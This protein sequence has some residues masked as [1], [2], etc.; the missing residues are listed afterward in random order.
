MVLLAGSA[1]AADILIVAQAP[2][3]SPAVQDAIQKAVSVLDDGRLRIAC[4]LGS[5]GGAVV[6]TIFFP[7]GT[8]RQYASK[9]FGSTVCGIL[10]SPKAM[11]WFA[12]DINLD[13]VVCMA[14]VVALLSWTVLQFAVPRAVDLFL[15]WW[16]GRGAKS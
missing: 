8:A 6:S 13:N 1:A 14:G 3:V 11:S 12:W 16:N 5:F 15:V 9:L 4:A 10:F 2:G 7:L